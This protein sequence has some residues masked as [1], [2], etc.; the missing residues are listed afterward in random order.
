MKGIYNSNDMMYH[1]HMTLPTPYYQDDHITLY[2]ADAADVVP[3][4]DRVDLLLT[5]PPYGIGEASNA[6]ASRSKL[7]ASKDYVR[8][9]WD[10]Q[11]IAM[12]LMQ[13][14]IDAATHAIIFG[15]NY[16]P[17]PPTSCWL[18]W[19]K[20]NGKN[21][22]ADCE[23]A[24]TNLDMAVRRVKWRW[25]G[26]L[27]EDPKHREHRYHPTQKPQPVMEWCIAVSKLQPKTV[28]D[29][30]AG[31]GTTLIAA[32]ALGCRAIGIERERD[33]CDII[34]QRIHAPERP[35]TYPIDEFIR[36][37]KPSLF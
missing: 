24:W 32:R 26:M 21:D 17:L 33:Y 11:P 14:C 8:K 4:L 6:N 30:F 19:D 29:P 9:S 16:Y 20:E 18:V 31:S 22:F 34:V 25:H 27:Q 23:L 5:D 1:E 13:T 7:A 37:S 12:S 2:H 3:H 15:G 10:N 36:G 35:M 28:L